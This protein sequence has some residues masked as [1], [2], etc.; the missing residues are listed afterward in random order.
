MFL[1]ATEINCR[2]VAFSNVNLLFSVLEVRS[3]RDKMLAGFWKFGKEVPFLA[4]ST[5]WEVPVLLGLVA[6]TLVSE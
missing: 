3:P 4:F 6:L 2:K 1:I 5:S